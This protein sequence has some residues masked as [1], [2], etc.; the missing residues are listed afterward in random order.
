[1]LGLASLPIDDHLLA[2]WGFDEANPTDIGLDRSKYA[3]TLTF[4]G[5]APPQRGKVGNARLFSSISG[6]YA[7][8]AVSA[9]ISAASHLTV[10]TWGSLASINSAGSMIRTIVACDGPSNATARQNT[11]FSLGVASDGAIVFRHDTGVAQPVVLKTAPGTIAI[12]HFYFIA[13]IRTYDGDGNAVVTP[14]LNGAALTWASATVN[15]VA[16]VNPNAPV[17]PPAGGEDS[18]CRVGMSQKNGDDFWDGLIDETSIHDTE[19]AFSPYIT[20]AYLKT[21]LLTNVTRLTDANSIQRVAVA[22]I[23][24]GGRWWIY[25][26]DRNCFAIRETSLGTFE[27][28]VQLTTGGT[29]AN[30]APLPAEVDQPKVIYE[31]ATGTLIVA[32]I[33]AGKVYKFTGILGD[34]P[35]TLNMPYTL[36]T[37]TIL[38]AHELSDFIGRGS[39][40]STTTLVADNAVYGNTGDVANIAFFTDGAFGVYVNGTSAGGY[41]LFMVVGG[42]EKA[43]ADVPS[44]MSLTTVAP[45]TYGA[46]YRAYI[47]DTEGRIHRELCSSTITDFEGYAQD[48][49]VTPGLI[50]INDNGDLATDR[51]QRGAGGGVGAD[52]V[53]V[54]TRTYPIKTLITDSFNGNGGGGGVSREGVLTITAS[55]PIKLS[56]SETYVGNGGGGGLFVSATSRG[57]TVTG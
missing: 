27:E 33:A 19:R 52:P 17:P 3:N 24:N 4:V 9:G 42:Q 37:S 47:L 50:R 34:A 5:V 14:I 29:A 13:I 15:G 57:K 7:T 40:G 41:R 53:L 39:S 6:T 10:L 28:E 20:G 43:V 31:T 51:V 32:F 44:G 11:V 25:I 12:D 56:L 38:K 16:Q 26:R 30:G 49:E 2:Y 23:A 22:N 8:C 18:T 36:D 45:R 55:T 48:D 1:M 35:A 54:V 46:G 21:A